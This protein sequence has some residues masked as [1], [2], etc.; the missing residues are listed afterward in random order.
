M[1]I[2]IG[3]D[4]Q[5]YGPATLEQLKGWLAEGRITAETHIRR[6]GEDAW[7]ALANLP[8]AF[9]PQQ[10]TPSAP[11]PLQQVEKIQRPAPMG[12]T[13]LL[14]CDYEIDVVDCFQRAF[15]LVKKNWKVAVV[16]ALLFGLASLALQIPSFFGGFISAGGKENVSAAAQIISATLNFISSIL[17]MLF[18]GLLYGGLS[19][20]FIRLKRGETPLA[21]DV[22]V[23]F[24]QSFKQLMLASVVSSLLMMLGLILCIVPGIYLWVSYS[25]V[26]ILILDRKMEFWDAM[27]LSRKMVAKHWFMIGFLV[28]A[29]SAVA[30]V[31]VIAC[32]IGILFTGPVA[33]AAVMCAYEDIFNPGST[34]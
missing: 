4:G 1:Y 3:G 25:F 23:G 34:S 20:F 30:A 24:K 13:A 33:V 16:A 21:S 2:I 9:N 8:E 18:M 29:A 10:A 5:E 14:S 31:G 17:C 11:V 12:E 6:Q 19:L 28:L 15:A 22:F 7:F 32:G 27:E 26:F